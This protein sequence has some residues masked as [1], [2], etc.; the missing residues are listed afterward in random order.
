MQKCYGITPQYL[1]T[2]EN[3]DNCLS[4]QKII[5]L[6]N[7]ANVTTDYILLGKTN[8]LDSNTNEILQS[9]TESNLENYLGIVKEIINILKKAS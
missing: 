5:F 7:K 1:G 9:L 3:G 6:A 4:V 8:I 2:I